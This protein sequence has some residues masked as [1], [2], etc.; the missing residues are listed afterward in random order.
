[1]T[2]SPSLKVTE[3]ETKKLLVKGSNLS[4]T[5]GNNSRPN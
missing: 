3:N 2:Q 4:I 1:M 5:I